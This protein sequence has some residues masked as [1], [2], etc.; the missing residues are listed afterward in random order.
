MACFEGRA[1]KGKLP[2]SLD[3]FQPYE[4]PRDLN[5][6]VFLRCDMHGVV[7]NSLVKYHKVFKGM[8]GGMIFGPKYLLTRCL[9]VRATKDPRCFFYSLKYILVENEFFFSFHASELL[10]HAN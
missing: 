10:V 6:L 2:Q 1:K 8:F 3:K 5:V 4:N 9:D 7:Q